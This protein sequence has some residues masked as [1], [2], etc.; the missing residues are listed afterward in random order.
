MSGGS[1]QGRGRGSHG[2]RDRRVCG[3]GNSYPSHIKNLN[4]KNKRLCSA[5]IHHV[6]DYGQIWAVDQIRTT[7]KKIVNHVGMIY[8]HDI[9]NELQNKKRIKIPQPEH[10]QQVKDKNLNR[11]ERLRNQHVRL[12]Q[13]RYIKL[14]LLETALQIQEDP[15]APVNLEMIINDID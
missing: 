6:F 1:K 15:E 5:L 4:N 12:M 8:G 13:A 3:R 7:W 10:T 14:Q 9:S 2:A 11:F